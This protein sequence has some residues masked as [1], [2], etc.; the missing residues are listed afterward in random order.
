M[1]G[2][3]VTWCKSC[4]STRH[5]TVMGIS[6]L[7]KTARNFES[8]RMGFMDTMIDEL[9]PELLSFLSDDEIEPSA[10]DLHRPTT[11]FSDPRLSPS[12]IHHPSQSLKAPCYAARIYI[13]STSLPI[14]QRSSRGSAQILRNDS[15]PTNE[16]QHPASRMSR[17]LRRERQLLPLPCRRNM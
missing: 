4:K 15:P 12:V 1:D 16:C 2:G 13:Q 10:N 3:L 17:R 9:I 6:A 11:R 5:S 14:S 8:D 7:F